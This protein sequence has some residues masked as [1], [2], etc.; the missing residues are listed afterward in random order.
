[1][2]EC[3][4]KSVRT[5]VDAVKELCRYGLLSPCVNIKNVYFINPDMGFRGSRVKKY[6]KNLDFKNKDV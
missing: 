6:P 2:E 5:F 1:M 4:I 3:R